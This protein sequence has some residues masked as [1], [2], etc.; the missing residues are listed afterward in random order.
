MVLQPTL[1]NTAEKHAKE[2]CMSSTSLPFKAC[3]GFKAGKTS[4]WIPVPSYT[5]YNWSKVLTNLLIC[6]RFYQ[7][8]LL[9]N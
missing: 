7:H 9:S 3:M 4:V 1:I 2:V 5:I 6:K 8:P